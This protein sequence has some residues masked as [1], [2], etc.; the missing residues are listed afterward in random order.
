MAIWPSGL[1]VGSPARAGERRGERAAEPHVGGW[2]RPRLLQIMTDAAVLTYIE[3]PPG[4][5]RRLPPLQTVVAAVRAGELSLQQLVQQLG[6]VLTSEDDV[7]RAGGTGLLAEVLG[8]VPGS[9]SAESCAHLVAFF[10]DRLKD[11]GCLEEVLCGLLA[12]LR[13]H[14]VGEAGAVLLAQAVFAELAV[15]ALPQRVRKLVYQIFAELLARYLVGLQPLAADFVAGVVAAMDGEKDP[16]NLMVTFQLVCGMVGG[17]EPARGEMA[18]EL[19]DVIS[20]YYPITFEAPPGDKFGVTGDG[21]RR[22]LAAAFCATPAFAPFCLALLADKLSSSVGTTKVQCLTDLARCAEVYGA[23]PLSEHFERLW[24]LI[25]EES[26]NIDARVAVAAAQT[27]SA[28]MGVFANAAHSAPESLTEGGKR[29]HPHAKAAVDAIVG[30]TTYTIQTQA[31]GAHQVTCLCRLAGAAS[32][33]SAELLSDLAAQML[34]PLLQNCD[35][36]RPQQ[37]LAV[38][39]L[40]AELLGAAVSVSVEQPFAAHKDAIMQLLATAVEC[41]AV[42]ETPTKAI[43]CMGALVSVSDDE[44]TLAMAGTSKAKLLNGEEITGLVSRFGQTVLDHALR[45]EG[46]MALS[47]ACVDSMIGISVGHEQRVEQFGL[48]PLYEKLHEL[49]AT[50]DASTASVVAN[51]LKCLV[52]LAKNTVSHFVFTIPRLVSELRGL[53]LRCAADEMDSGMVEMTCA[54]F[55]SLDGAFGEAVGDELDSCAAQCSGDTYSCVA[56]YVTQ[57]DCAP[58]EELIVAAEATLRRLVQVMQPAG[59][60]TV[61]TVAVA[62]LLGDSPGSIAAPAAGRTSLLRITAAVITAL[63]ST[64][65][66]DRCPEL[67]T[68]LS[69]VGNWDP[70]A[71]TVDARIAGQCFG[72]IFNKDTGTLADAQQSVI[73]TLSNAC[74]GALHT[75]AVLIFAVMLDLILASCFAQTPPV[76]KS[77][78]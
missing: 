49:L 57:A 62:R 7:K 52:E 29:W 40:L 61:A 56:E 2:T 58:T 26:G 5:E 11:V 23:E 73:E 32:S 16:R 30:R 20:C 35:P 70:P 41:T 13:G 45:G 53:L 74:Q 71:T 3:L 24:Q 44:G 10:C 72:S 6:A 28:V 60:S 15:Q 18:E 43:K 34:P 63:S 51:V 4:D 25:I 1:C 27:V 78:C 22:E 9:T 75:R 19:F 38:V 48:A 39:S 31:C 76:V 50:A 46:A 64:V 12:L 14:S 55:A 59:Q 69:D 42:E 17:L 68:V 33:V 21:L 47:S 37:Q 36:T 66:L 65:V 8:T 67:L 54:V 77:G